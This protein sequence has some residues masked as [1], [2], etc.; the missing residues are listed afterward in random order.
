MPISIRL[1]W[2]YPVLIKPPYFLKNEFESLF[3]KYFEIFCDDMGKFSI[4]APACFVL[5]SMPSVPN[6]ANTTSSHEF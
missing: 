5:P 6:E 1:V 4:I 2:V 3:F